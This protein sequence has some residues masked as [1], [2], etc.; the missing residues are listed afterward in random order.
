M[1][2]AEPEVPVAPPPEIPE[3]P[4][5]VVRHFIVADPSL[6]KAARVSGLTLDDYQLPIRTLHVS[7]EGAVSMVHIRYTCA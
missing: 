4:S 7:G 2:E 3:D 6:E 1:A 5:E